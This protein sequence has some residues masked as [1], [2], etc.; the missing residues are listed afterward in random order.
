MSRR[1]LA[2]L[3]AAALLAVLAGCSPTV[4]ATPAADANDPLCAAVT[5]RLPDTLGELPQ[6]DTDAQAT[7]AWGDPTQVLLTCGV[8]VPRASSLPCV[9]VD[10]I[11]WIQDDR[12]APLYIFT[13]FGRTPAVDVA[14]RT[15]KVSGDTVLT[16]L[17][18]AVRETKP[19]GLECR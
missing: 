7:G 2:A 1:P 11:D 18:D 13:S 14:L 16:D 10:G 4:A 12:K 3:A 15:T 19:N 5:V 6:R 17:A 9:R 8:K